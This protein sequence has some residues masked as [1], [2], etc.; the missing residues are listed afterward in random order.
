MQNN[1]Q[2]GEHETDNSKERCFKLQRFSEDL[3]ISLGEIVISKCLEKHQALC[4]YPSMFGKYMLY[5]I[6][7]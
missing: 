3:T 7:N 4:E 6:G 1:W 2:G 5:R